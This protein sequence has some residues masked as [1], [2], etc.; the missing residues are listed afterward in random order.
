MFEGK[1]LGFLSLAA[2][3]NDED[4]SKVG[5]LVVRVTNLEAAAKDIW[6]LV[7]AVRAIVAEHYPDGTKHDDSEYE[8]RRSAM[9][10][11]VRQALVLRSALGPAPEP[12]AR[13]PRCLW[14][15][16]K[17][18]IGK[19]TFADPPVVVSPCD[20]HFVRPDDASRPEKAR[21][22]CGWCGETNPDRI[23]PGTSSATGYWCIARHD[24]PFDQEPET[25]AEIIRDAAAYLRFCAGM[26]SL[27]PAHGE[28]GA[29]YYEDAAMHLEGLS[30]APWR[31]R[32]YHGPLGDLEAGDLHEEAVRGY[33]EGRW[34][35]DKRQVASLAVEVL[36]RRSKP[37]TSG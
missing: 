29:R 36:R 19:P 3:L 8:R 37:S 35:Y 22:T 12:V 34:G 25:R 32:E 26:A 5:A 6:P 18:F 17:M 28:R 16:D 9:A 11:L 15:N 23:A 7:E 20:E 1:I 24:G 33:A 27:S 14:S 10:A 31:G 30:E 2:H 4:L 13:C 21:P